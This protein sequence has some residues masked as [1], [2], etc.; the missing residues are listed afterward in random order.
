MFVLSEVDM[1]EDYLKAGKI[2]AEALK[3]GASLIKPGASWIKVADKIEKKII[4]LGGG[5]AFPAQMS[6]N[7]VAA[8]FIPGLG[9]D[10][11]FKDEVICLD[12]GAHVNGSIADNACTIDLSGKHA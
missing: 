7:D 9:E 4:D 2:A 3:Y 8:H 10:I 12:V 6:L 5:I 1:E 11:L